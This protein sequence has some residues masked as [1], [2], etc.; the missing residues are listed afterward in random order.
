MFVDT[1]LL[2]L[3]ANDARRAGGHAA[4]G[5][6][7]LSRSSL[8]TAMFGDF[9]AAEVFHDALN[10]THAAHVGLLQAHQD[11]LMSLGGSAYRAAAEFVDTD[12]Q[13]AAVLQ[14]VRCISST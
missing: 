5:A 3:G 1:G 13:N 7:R 11:A 12:D 9:A 4:E 6:D 10:L 8:H 2:R 14:A